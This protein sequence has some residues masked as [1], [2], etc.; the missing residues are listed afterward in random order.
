MQDSI[1]TRVM[2]RNM[3]IVFLIQ[4]Q[5]KE[6]V[7]YGSHQTDDVSVINGCGL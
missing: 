4:W 1:E 5:A 2:L 6:T 3:Q 7:L